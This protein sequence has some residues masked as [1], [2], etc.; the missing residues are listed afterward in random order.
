M[1]LLSLLVHPSLLECL[2][3]GPGTGKGVNPLWNDSLHQDMDAAV[4]AAQDTAEP[5]VSHANFAGLFPLIMYWCYAARG[6]R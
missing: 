5:A 1:N 4:A 6:V 3:G 2:R